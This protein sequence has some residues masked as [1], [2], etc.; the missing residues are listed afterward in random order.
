MQSS[1]Q[2]PA[3][4]LKRQAKFE[5]KNQTPL[6]AHQRMIIARANMLAQSFKGQ[7]LPVVVG[8]DQFIFNVKGIE[9]LKF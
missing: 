2:K 9:S 1:T 6:Q 3:G 7:L 4:G 5:Q 8:T